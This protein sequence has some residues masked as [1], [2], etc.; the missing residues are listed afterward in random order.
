MRIALRLLEPK[1]SNETACTVVLALDHSYDVNSVYHLKCNVD[2]VLCNLD[3]AL[4]FRCRIVGAK[5][6]PDAPIHRF[7]SS[8]TTRSNRLIVI[9][10]GHTQ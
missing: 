7:D 3:P 9:A 2:Q 4:G 5:N 1:I 8:E 10:L 6:D